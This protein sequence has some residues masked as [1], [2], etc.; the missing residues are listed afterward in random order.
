MTAYDTVEN[1]DLYFEDRLHV[2]QW[3]QALAS[4][5]EKAL[6]EA[7]MRIDRLRFSGE[8]TVDTQELEFPRD[9]DTVVPTDI[10]I[11]CYEI[12]YELLRGANPDKEISNIGVTN[13]RF[14]GVSVSWDKDTEVEHIAAGIPSVLAWNYLR[15]YLAKIKSIRVRRVN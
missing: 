12:A 3:T 7:T 2:Y 1:A 14:E 5:K 11:A 4:D 15:P 9:G 10:K 6:I 13:R 8:K